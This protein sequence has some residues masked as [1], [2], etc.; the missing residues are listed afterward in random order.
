MQIKTKIMF[1]S[2]CNGFPDI[3]CRPTGRKAKNT[4]SRKSQETINVLLIF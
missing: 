4:A 2:I 3:P 1:I